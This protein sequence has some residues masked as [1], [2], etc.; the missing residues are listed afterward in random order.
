MIQLFISI[1]IFVLS[2]G[3]RASGVSED[4][5]KKIKIPSADE[6]PMERG[7]EVE[8]PASVPHIQE[9]LVDDEVAQV[10]PIDKKRPWEAPAYSKQ[11]KN[12]TTP[13]GYDEKTFEIPVGLK[14]RVDFWLDIYTKYTTQQGVLHDSAHVGVV[15]EVVDFSQIQSDASLSDRQKTKARR[16]LV[17]DRKKEIRERLLKLS[18]LSSA[19]GLEGE[20][21]RFW[22]LFEKIDEPN[23]FKIATDRK[24]LR[25][26]LGQKDRFAQGIYYSGQ[27]L[28]EMEKIYSEMGLPIEL[29]RLPFVESSF[30]VKARSRVG[31]SGIWQFMRYTGK[32]FLRIHSAADERNDPLKATRASARLLKLN[33][34]ML[35]KWPLAITG[36]NH[37]PAGVARMVKKFQTNDIVELVDERYGRFGFASANFY[38]CFLAA[39][40]AEKEAKKYFGD[41]YWGAPIDAYEIK[42][43]NKVNRKMLL[44]WFAGDEERARDF[45]PHL[46][47]TFWS[48]YGYLGE[49]DFLRVPIEKAKT[50]QV[51]ADR[52]T[53]IDLAPKKGGIATPA[54]TVQYVIGTGQTL[55]E[56]AQ[57][58]GVNI[59]QIMDLND[60]ENPRR[61]R[62]GQKILVP[63]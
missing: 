38:A 25:F 27:Y 29:T 53:P 14:P 21:L 4:D 18:S 1:S 11:I 45:N 22:N 36:Y 31:A 41:V 54:E 43:K 34:E 35:Q 63:K 55:S 13:L 52:P 42:P 17:E 9:E 57:E 23:K 5:Q 47:R 37:G 44:S 50:A 59:N 46:T 6:N 39:L 30:N 61:I 19:D 24:R 48:G 28:A 32:K 56:I 60:I 20:D 2:C 8:R 49:K 12:G 58:L 33:Y 51:E 15:Y 40:Y 10:E 62:A 16:K 7:I 3:L 26:Q